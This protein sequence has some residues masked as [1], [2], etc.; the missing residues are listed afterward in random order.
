MNAKLLWFFLT[1]SVS[2]EYPSNSVSELH[3]VQQPSSI[4]AQ[5]GSRV[6]LA[7]SAEGDG[8]LRYQWCKVDAPEGMQEIFNSDKSALVLYSLSRYNGGKYVCKV[9][10]TGGAKI[11]TNEVEITVLEKD[12]SSSKCTAKT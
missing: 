5:L 8:K 10:G 7:C 3:I 9:T 1:E 2:C 11:S 4:A 12:S 6:T